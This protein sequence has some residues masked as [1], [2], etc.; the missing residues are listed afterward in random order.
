MK[1]SSSELIRLS[2]LLR[3]EKIEKDGSALPF[4]YQKHHSF[5]MGVEA[6]LVFCHPV[7]DRLRDLYPF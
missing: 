2:A 1:L 5:I 3:A 7:G 4:P 6:F